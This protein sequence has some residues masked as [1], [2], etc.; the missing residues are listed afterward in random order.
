MLSSLFISLA[1]FA[2][3]LSYYLFYISAT[4]PVAYLEAF[5]L[6]ESQSIE[7]ATDVPLSAH[8]LF[9]GS[10]CIKAASA[11]DAAAEFQK[12]LADVPLDIRK[13]ILKRALPELPGESSARYETDFT[14][15]GT[16]THILAFWHTVATRGEVRSCISLA[17]GSAKPANRI[18]GMSTKKMQR[19]IGYEKC[20]CV[21]FFCQSCPLIEE[22][23]ES[24]PVTVPVRWSA[25]QHKQMQLTLR[26]HSVEMITNVPQIASGAGLQEVSDGAKSTVAA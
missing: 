15:D 8:N 19:T 14:D 16:V 13:R 11:D 22:E 26:A 10:A 24:V 1:V 9:G 4:D 18:V 5:A 7:N 12:V 17:G 23:E 6:Q 2:G 25:K 20:K 21:L 3:G